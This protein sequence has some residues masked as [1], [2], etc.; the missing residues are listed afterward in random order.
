MS[1][2]KVDLNSID[3]LCAELSSAVTNLAAYHTEMNLMGQYY[4]NSAFYKRKAGES[5]CPLSDNWLK[6]FADKNI[7][8]TSEAFQVKVVGRPD[9]RE[10]ADIREKIILAVRQKS[11]YDLLKK[12]WARDATKRSVAISEVGFDLNERCAFIKRYDP[13]YVFWKMSNDNEQKVSAF[14]A[15]FPITKQE[16]WDTYG[17]I[18]TKDTVSNNHFTN[19][20][21][22]FNYM[23]GQDWFTMAIRWDDKFRVAWIG[24]KLIEEPHEHNVGEMPIDICAPFPS[25]E[26]N[27]AGHFYMQ[28]LVPMQA[29]LNDTIRRRSNIVKRHSNPI[30]WGRNIKERGYDDVK[31]AL[32]NADTGILGLGK[33]GEVGILQL[34]QITVLKEHEDAIKSDMQR[35]SGFAAASF[36]ES[37]GANTSGEALGLY[38]TPTQKHI[39]DQNI[40]WVAFEQAQNA[41]ILRVYDNFG[42]TGEKFSLKGYAPKSTV[43]ASGGKITKVKQAGGYSIEFTR[44]NINGDYDNRVIPP[45]VIPKDELGEKTFWM[46]E[47]KNGTISHTTAYEKIGLESPEDEKELLLLEKGEPLLN[48]KGL[49]DIMGSLPQPEAPTALP[50]GVPPLPPPPNLGVGVNNGA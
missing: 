2:K 1:Q 5:K 8:Y 34:N 17:V 22:Y 24:D 20:D 39:D 26:K 27:Q 13:R 4:L 16:A 43:S 37:V 14:W 25:D 33:E 3:S 12:R 50:Q 19:T 10:N 23:D 7:H 29:E 49:S 30:I 9:D 35:L 46:T 28:D 47:A 6:I 15:V 36:G 18:P 44:E 45:T 38:F 42:R 32:K 40:S 48:P 21:P 41:K 11:G 31:D